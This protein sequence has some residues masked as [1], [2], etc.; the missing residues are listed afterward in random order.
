MITLRILQLSDLHIGSSETD[1]VIEAITQWAKADNKVYQNI[2]YLVICGNLLFQPNETNYRRAIDGVRKLAQVLLIRHE[3]GLGPAKCSRVLIVPG[4][5]DVLDDGGVIFKK[6]Y[7]EFFS[8]DRKIA[9]EDPLALQYRHL[10][11]LTLI[12]GCYWNANAA[13]KS[14]KGSNTID[15]SKKKLHK[16]VD[17]AY[18]LKTQHDVKYLD[19]TPTVFVTSGNPVLCAQLIT[20]PLKTFWRKT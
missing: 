2:N 3:D 1:D 16:I 9:L 17:L 14:K 20:T 12:G 10:K 4:P 5:K 18:K 13:D 6:F 15:E 19:S 7:K 8:A 11:D